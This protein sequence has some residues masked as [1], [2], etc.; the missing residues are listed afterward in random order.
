MYWTDIDFINDTAKIQRSDLDGNNVEDLITSNLVSPEDIALDTTSGKLYW[1]D[2][3][4]ETGNILFSNLD[5][6]DEENLV[7]GLVQPS[8]IALSLYPIVSV[9]PLLKQE[10][11]IS[12]LFP[13][14]EYWYDHH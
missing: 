10:G 8:S 9:F 14:S 2:T 11:I 7:V 4:G 13:Q 5:C 12:R 3:D 1:T 6:T